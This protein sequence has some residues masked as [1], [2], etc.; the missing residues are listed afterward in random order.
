MKLQTK[1][2][3]SLLAGLI[4][5]VA[6]AQTFQYYRMTR[7]ISNFSKDNINLLKEREEQF[8]MN[9]YR[10]IARGVS[11]S[12][13]RGEM[14]KFNNLLKA[15]TKV[16]GL[17]EFSLYD[18]DG[19]VVYSSDPK[20]LGKKL[21][22]E[23]K[24]RLL[25][26]SSLPPLWENESISIYKSQMINGDCIRCHLD[27]K[28]DGLGGVIGFRFS[29]KSLADAKHKA[30]VTI[31]DMKNS[32][33]IT[34]LLSMI[35]IIVVLMVTMQ[36]FVRKFVSLPLQS[37]VSMLKD[38]AR[39]EGDLTRRL[40]V[41]SKDEVGEVAK[42]FNLLMEKLQH[43]IKQVS[44]DMADLS[45][46]SKQLILIS[47]DMGSKANDMNLQS[48]E[49]AEA[50]ENTAGNIKNM[51]ESAE[52][53]SSKVVETTSSSEEVSTN[54]K[55]IEVAANNV[56][57]S[58][59]S[60]AVAIEEMY[61]TLNDVAK[62]SARGAN[63]TSDA[64]AKADS[65][66]EIVNTLGEG[67]KE[68]GDV[69]EL[70]KGIAAQT[71]L[72]ALNASIE[73]AGAGDA[74]KGF[75]V[76]ANEVKELARQ[77]AKATE[78]IREKVEGMQANTAS[79][80]DAINSIVTVIGEINV[81]MGTIAAAVEE[82]TATTNEI[83]KN[84][85]TTA[86][87]AAAASNNVQKVVQLEE[88]LSQNMEKVAQAALAIAKDANE[89]SVSTERVSNNVVKVSETIA[90]SSDSAEQVKNQAED[91]A[92]IANQIQDIMGQFII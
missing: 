56:S 2:I 11:G 77:T 29:T 45:S 5:V 54:L 86:N 40:S 75:A 26:N 91:L 82:Q 4:V 67:A 38:I 30:A 80:V 81:I 12:L 63:V 51:A 18:M 61:A 22:T 92:N 28:A 25:T 90:A 44:G 42:W 88:A 6:A 89:A 57:I 33:F 41:T 34:S 7:Y 13:E 36:F 74:G 20:F 59:N 47:N 35:G 79:A 16:E 52:A 64:S 65:T 48:G 15:Q 58:V 24:K 3:M 55:D 85:T 37:T 72:L 78:D 62:N 46:S 14:Q 21:S 70:I 19:K 73:A 53:V 76:V 1:L 9:M 27:W 83:S 60:V 17:L 68:I 66:S 87:D 69:V 23:M 84:V 43:M 50:T 71:N 10:S 39:G 49:A 31:S 8:A 32:A